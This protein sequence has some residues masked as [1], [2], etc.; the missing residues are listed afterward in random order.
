MSQSILDATKVS[1]VSEKEI[2]KAITKYIVQG[3][4]PHSHVESIHFRELMS[5]VAPG[6]QCKLKRT[7]KRSILQM[8]VALRK[9]VIDILSK[10]IQGSLLLLMVGL[11]IA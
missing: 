2:D 3:T 7:I 4:L 11:T 9:L 8:Y 5:Q 1:R 6:Y 10:T